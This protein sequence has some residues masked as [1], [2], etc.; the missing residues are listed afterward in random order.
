M[1]TTNLMTQQNILNES[2]KDL[3][4]IIIP[5]YNVKKYLKQC[6]ESVVNQTY[7]NIEIILVNDGSTDGSGD[8]CDEYAIKDSRVRVIHKK[9]AGLGL[10]RNSGLEKASGKYVTFIDSDDYADI[11]M[12]ESLYNCILDEKADTCIGGYK[13]VDDEGSIIFEESYNYSIFTGKN[14]QKKLFYRM[15]GSSPEKSDAI[16]MSVWNSMYS[17]EIIRENAIKFPS[18]R[19]F[20]SEDIIF[21]SDYY[22]NAKKVIII[23][24]TAYNYRI[25]ALSLTMKYNKDRFEK[26]KLLCSTLI[27]RLSLDDIDNDAILRIKRMFFVNVRTCILQEVK[28]YSSPSYN[29]AINNIKSICNDKYLHSVID[30]YPVEKMGKKQQIFIKLIQKRMYKTFYLLFKFKII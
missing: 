7:K 12:I 17:M 5:V 23:G 30:S 20:I 24:S 26:Y 2:N 6:I 29:K 11:N 15:L 21:D 27:D 25:N 19:E 10:A 13:R 8:I 22:K 28:S 3:I 14:I 18:E 16:R 9:N 1:N 4:T